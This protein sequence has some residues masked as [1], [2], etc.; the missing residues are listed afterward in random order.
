MIRLR[1]LGMTDLRGPDA[2]EIRS[3]LARPRELGL[4]VFLAA[5]SPPGFHRRDRLLGI[6]W[7]D[8]EE[9]R[10]RHS[11]NQILYSLRNALGKSVLVSRGADEVGVDARRLWCDA[12]AFESALEAGSPAE[13][14]ELYRGELLPGF[15]IDGAG[16]F[17]RWLEE[18]RRQLGGR[19]AEAA[20]RLAATHEEGGNLAAAAHWARRALEL[21]DE[22]DEATLRRVLRLLHRVGDREGALRVYRRFARGLEE[23][24]GLEPSPEIRA[25]ADELAAPSP[26]PEPAPDALAARSPHPESISGDGRAGRTALTSP[27]AD[28]AGRLPTYR[29]PLVGRD[30]ELARILERLADPACRLLTLV[31]PGGVG[32]TRLAIAAAAELAKGEARFIPLTHTSS[33]EPLVSAMAR[34]LELRFDE[35]AP[36]EDQIEAHLADREILLVLDDFDL[37]AAQAG[38]LT[39]ILERAPGAKLLVTARSVLN[40]RDEWV[41]PVDGLAFPRGERPEEAERSPAVR[42]FVELARRARED[43]RLSEGNRKEVARICELVEGLPLA[44]E[45]A[46]GWTRVLS[47]GAIRD[48][49]EQGL[50]FLESRLRDVPDRHRSL[51]ATF[52]HSWDLLQEAEA[53]AFRRLSVF[54]GGFSREAAE[55]VTGAALPLLGALVD[56]SLLR[57]PGPER[58][59]V[60]EGLR[61]FAAEKLAAEP[62]VEEETRNRHAGFYLHLVA[63]LEDSLRGQ[64]PERALSRFAEELDNVRA[65]WRRATRNAA[66]DQLDAALDG[67]FAFYDIRGWHREAAET[68]GGA[69]AALEANLPAAP[70]AADAALSLG[71]LLA[72]QG[73]AHLRLGELARA[74]ELL[75]RSL[76]ML[77]TRD[78][79]EEVAFALDR[80]GVAAYREG[81]FKEAKV[82]EER[83]LAL[84]RE[85]GEPSAIATSLNN[86]GSLAYALG[87]Y[88]E[89]EKLCREAL[90]IYEELEDPRGAALAFH[91]LG[92]IALG[93]GDADEAR[94][95]LD[96]AVEVARGANLGLLLAR[97]LCTL[98]NLATAHGRDEQA[99]DYFR[100]TVRNAAKLGATPIALEALVGLG[101]SLHRQ[102]NPERALEMLILVQEHPSAG[103]AHREAAARLLQALEPGLPPEARKAARK[104]GRRMTL[105]DAAEKL[106]KALRASDRAPA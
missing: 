11:L 56:T 80:S 83:A 85:V 88:G 28:S 13:A 16:N 43:F 91:N 77:G 84:R 17:E 10:G 104:R 71:R 89:A 96:R 69:A 61:Q 1:V 97:S 73:A 106:S 22:Y 40:L 75:D 2:E 55:E 82:A 87:D 76:S 57:R 54:R 44:L 98:G 7:P 27:S 36:P 4:L 21:G 64:E 23:E 102:G 5:A 93:R 79:P 41:F 67:L 72:R 8:R 50:D 68:F 74:R 15:Y 3:V 103:E 31:G 94:T 39:R 19:A 14:L 53:D 18:R 20:R 9:S 26:R 92:C 95:H 48:Q 86:L 105:S 51:W 30:A 63:R 49:L 37:L 32:K 90:A 99:S 65:A 78:A 58:Y 66:I 52:R 59:E 33:P 70:D 29:T 101:R 81:Q 38:R 12:A 47:C 60:L 6:F 62:A 100:E 46:A 34:A 35:A 45:L 42:L 24:L 25:L